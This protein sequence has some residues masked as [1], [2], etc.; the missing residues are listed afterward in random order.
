MNTNI[1]KSVL[2]QYH[3][4]YDNS[5]YTSIR[6]RF[7]QETVGE[8]VDVDLHAYDTAVVDFMNTLIDTCFEC[9]ASPNYAG[10]H[11]ILARAAAWSKLSPETVEKI[12][13]YLTTF[14]QVGIVAADDFLSITR[15]LT[16]AYAVQDRLREASA[17]ANRVHSWQGRAAYHLLVAAEYLTKSVELLLDQYDNASYLN[18]KLEH[19]IIRMTSALHEGIRYSD[20]PQYFDFKNHRF[21]SKSDQ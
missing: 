17:Y 1:S 6:F 14:Q 11:I 21:P 16:C 7:I 9:C 4:A 12:Y 19:G 3:A 20:R 13:Y 15:A 18:E 2:E 10:S 8:D 5:V